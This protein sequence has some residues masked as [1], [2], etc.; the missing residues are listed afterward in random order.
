MS[1]YV[2]KIESTL[3][4]QEAFAYMADFSNARIGIPV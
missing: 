1:R 3:S 4:P 2:A